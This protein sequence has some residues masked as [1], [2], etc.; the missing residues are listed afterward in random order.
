MALPLM[1]T[2][3]IQ[4]AQQSAGPRHPFDVL[5]TTHMGPLHVGQEAKPA[6]ALQNSSKCARCLRLPRPCKSLG[7]G[8]VL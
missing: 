5:A 2:N 1:V 3:Q 7:K 6:E 8:E 4:H